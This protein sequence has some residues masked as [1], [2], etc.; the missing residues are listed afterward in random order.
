MRISPL[1]TSLSLTAGAHGYTFNVLDHLAGITPYYESAQ[2]PFDPAPPQGCKTT[3]ATYLT[4]H[5]SINGN[6]YDSETY[7]E[8]FLKKLANTTVDWS[9][10]GNLSFLAT[11]K[12]PFNADKLERVTPVGVEEATNLGKQVKARYSGF[13]PPQQVWTSTAERTVVSADAFIAGYGG[14]GSSQLIQIGEG[15]ESGAN[16]LTAYNSCPAYSASRGSEE[17]QVST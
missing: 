10:A 12:T 9:R 13:R 2:P 3:R 4:R 11:W 17:S 1:L 6:D 8:P 15:K 14:N 7:I 16:S 5:S